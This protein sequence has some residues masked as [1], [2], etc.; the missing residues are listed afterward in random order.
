M[1]GPMIL[2]FWG[3]ALEFSKEIELIRDTCIQKL[4][5]SIQHNIKIFIMRN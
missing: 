2:L 5:Y 1:M 3:F 4:I